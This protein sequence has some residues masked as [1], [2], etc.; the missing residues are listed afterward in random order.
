MSNGFFQKK[1]SLVVKLV[2]CLLA[3]AAF[4]VRIQSPDIFQK[5]KMG[6]LNK[7]MANTFY[8]AKKKEEEKRRT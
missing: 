5:Y 2:V 8:P 7:G 4:W 3:T 1:A 6:N